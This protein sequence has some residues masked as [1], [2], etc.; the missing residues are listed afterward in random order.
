[1]W[2][3][4]KVCSMRRA[5]SISLILRVKVFSELKRKFRA[6]CWVIV[7]A[8]CAFFPASAL[9]PMARTMPSTSTPV[10]S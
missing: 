7:D 9:R 3:F 10:C 2:S 4:S 5:S 6:T 8:P 1:M